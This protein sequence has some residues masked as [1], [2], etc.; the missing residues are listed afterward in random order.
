MLNHSLTLESKF[1]ELTYT[2]QPILDSPP[3]HFL[4]KYR[5][6]IQDSD[7]DKP[8]YADNAALR[9]HFVRALRHCFPKSSAQRTEVEIS[10]KKDYTLN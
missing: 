9:P 1:D 8:A 3:P 2:I 6:F 5:I 7:D 4:Y 10:M